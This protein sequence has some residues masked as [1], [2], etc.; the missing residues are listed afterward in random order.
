VAAYLNRTLLDGK[1]LADMSPAGLPIVILNAS[2][3]NNASTLSFIQPHFDFLC[4][5]LS[6]CP[7]ASAVMASA[8]ARAVRAD[9]TAQAKSGFEMWAKHVNAIRAPGAPQVGVNFAV[10]TFNQI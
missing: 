9:R 7:L 6:T 8:A 10:L 3:L 5:D 4:S 2:N 1:T